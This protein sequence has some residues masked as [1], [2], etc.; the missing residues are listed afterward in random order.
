MGLIHILPVFLAYI[1][2]AIP[3]GYLLTK[4]A[5][6]LNILEQGSGNIGSTNVRR[7]AGK[8]ISIQVQ[9]LDMLKGF[10]P[11]ILVLMTNK[12]GYI[13]IPDYYIL[14]IAFSTIIGH[15]FSVFL[16]FRGGKGVNTTLG[17]T[18]LLAPVEVLSA[19]V[20]YFIVKWRF[21]YVSIGSIVLACALPCSAIF[22]KEKTYLII[23]LFLCCFMILFR[24]L[25]NI[26]RLIAGSELH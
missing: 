12:S 26:K 1:I 9:I 11:V 8:R 19:V 15:N 22:C 5:T 2:G 14:I 4:R 3:F 25:P 24:H 6:G 13:P 10:L 17:A 21:R 20:I 18:L 16:R 23:Y 7:I